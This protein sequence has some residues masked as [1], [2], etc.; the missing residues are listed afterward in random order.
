[1]K[2]QKQKDNGYTLSELVKTIN[3]GNEEVNRRGAEKMAQISLAANRIDTSKI[4]F[5][6]RQ[7]L[8][9]P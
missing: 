8:L 4:G 2:R 5:R 7:S 3:G 9:K 1:M 6:E